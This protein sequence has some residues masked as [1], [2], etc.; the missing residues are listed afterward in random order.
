MSEC[1]MFGMDCEARCMVSMVADEDN[2]CFLVGTNNIKNENH[3]N[4]L[5][6]D[7]EASRLMSKSFRHP[8]GEVR[9]IAA[10]PTKSNLLATATADCE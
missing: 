6:M 9:A 4:K 8:A 2:V 1:L 5:Y 10:H 3:V 7:N